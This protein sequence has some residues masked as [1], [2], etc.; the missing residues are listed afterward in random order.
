MEKYIVK[1]TEA[2]RDELTGISRKGVMKA[3]KA[4][5]ALIL[6]N[7]DRGSSIRK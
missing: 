2:E 7:C 5:N 1:L 6:L 3:Q 4:V